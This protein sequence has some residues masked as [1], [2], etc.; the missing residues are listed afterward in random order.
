MPVIRDF[1]W[2]TKASENALVM[3]FKESTVLGRTRCGGGG[4]FI[5]MGTNVDMSLCCAVKLWL[6]QE[7]FGVTHSSSTKVVPSRFIVL[8]KYVVTVLLKPACFSSPSRHKAVTQWKWPL[9]SFCS[10]PRS[11]AGQS[12]SLLMP[13]QRARKKWWVSGKR[14][15]ARYGAGGFTVTD[16]GF[17]PHRDDQQPLPTGN[18]W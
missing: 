14:K 5:D 16:V 9:S 8:K 10:L 4:G 13:V 15:E 1:Q 18:R 11:S 3:G 2:H 17:V 6:P 12:Q 7:Y